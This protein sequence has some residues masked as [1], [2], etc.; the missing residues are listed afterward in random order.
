MQR[1]FGDYLGTVTPVGGRWSFP[2]SLQH[3][4]RYVVGRACLVGDAAHAIHPIAGQGLNLGLR[5]AAALAQIAVDAA[6]LGGDIGAAD[7]LRR[8]QTWRRFDIVTLQL[9]TDTLNRLFS[10]DVAPLRVV[11][12]IGLGAVNRIP[13]LKRFFMKHAMGMLGDLPRLIKGEA[14]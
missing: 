6:R 10:N 9:A 11:R 7:V 3:A 2:L 4:D 1:R 5:D 14:L 8:Y 12:D 13:P